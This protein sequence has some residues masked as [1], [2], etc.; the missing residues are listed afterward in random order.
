MTVMATNKYNIDLGVLTPA[1]L[2]E[3]PERE[4]RAVVDAD[5]KRGATGTAPVPAWISAAL[6]GPLVERWLAALQAALA[7]VDS[8]IDLKERSCSVHMADATSEAE[9]RQLATECERSLLGPRRFRGALLEIMPEAKRLREG[10]V[11]LLEEAIRTHRDTIKAD[12]S[13]GPSLADETL[14][15]VL[16]D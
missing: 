8:Q 5:L 7:N 4:F 6:R 3:L 2:T 12:T 11:G 1:S 10:R 14:W 13:V 15:S 16:D 9:A